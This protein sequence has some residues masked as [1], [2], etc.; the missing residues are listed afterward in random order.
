MFVLLRPFAVSYSL[1]PAVSPVLQ[2]CL[3]QNLEPVTGIMFDS[4][5]VVC[6]AWIVSYSIIFS[7][8]A[9]D[10]EHPA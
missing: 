10:I 4:E 8:E 7:F 3:S 1:L 2:A 5:A 9:S 6:C